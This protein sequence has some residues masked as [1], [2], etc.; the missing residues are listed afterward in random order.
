[1]G[2]FL[3]LFDYC[4]LFFLSL[5]LNGYASNNMPGARRAAKGRRPANF[6]E[7]FAGPVPRS[8]G[9]CQGK[10]VFLARDK[11]LHRVR[12]WHYHPFS[13]SF[14]FRQKKNTSLCELPFHHYHTYS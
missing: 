14:I 6:T 11:H 5:F 12:L 2:Q 4:G 7:Q 1:L 3:R 10:V 13:L 9:H 8:L